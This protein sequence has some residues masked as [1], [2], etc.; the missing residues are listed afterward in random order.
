MEE[1]TDISAILG[2][3]IYALCFCDEVVYIGQ[4]KRMLARIYTHR[5]LCERKRSGKKLETYL[6]V[7]I[8]TFSK[9]YIRP[10]AYEDM[11]RIE[12]EM[13][14][15]YRPKYNTNHMPASPK[16][17]FKE[18]GIDFQTFIASMIPPGTEVRM[19]RV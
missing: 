3:G 5:N 4:A 16:R 14:L 7:K 11:D 9:V 15:K 10:C 17:S 6:K 12:K 19:R 1:G 8:V 13:I 2:P 18:L